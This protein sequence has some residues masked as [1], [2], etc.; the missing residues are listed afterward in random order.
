MTKH[1]SA[2]LGSGLERREVL[3]LLS[4]GG[5]AFASAL[6]GCADRALVPRAPARG[7]LPRRSVARDFFFLQLSDTHWGFSGP[8]NPDAATVLRDTIALINSSPLHPD[9]VM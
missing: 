2:L 8:E 1:K 7:N 5:V 3:R 4:I 6:A 9:F